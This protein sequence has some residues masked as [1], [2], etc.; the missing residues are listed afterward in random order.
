MGQHTFLKAEYEQTMQDS[1]EKRAQDTKTLTEKTAAKANTE[2]DLQSHKDEKKGAE[3]ELMATHEV[4]SSL[5]SECDWLLQYADT[6]KE[7]RAGEISSLQ[8]AKAI[9]SGAD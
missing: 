9:L 6:R 3:G 2:T 4:I 8:N 5:H 7:A 1:A